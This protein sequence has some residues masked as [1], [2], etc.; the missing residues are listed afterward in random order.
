M[1]AAFAGDFKTQTGIILMFVTGS[2]SFLLNR[3]WRQ[4]RLDVDLPANAKNLAAPTFARSQ[5]YY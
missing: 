3:R 5:L 1:K 2:G 4:Q